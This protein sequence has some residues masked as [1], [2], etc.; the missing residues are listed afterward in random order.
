MKS[1]TDDGFVRVGKVAE[2]EAHGQFSKW[3]EDHEILVFKWKGGIKAL[4]NICPHLGGP[5]GFHKLHDGCFTCVW[6][7]FQFSA[8]DGRLVYPTEPKLLNFRLRE[9]TLKIEDGVIW[10]RLVEV[11]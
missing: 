8:E 7:N 1:K 11:Q 5:V 10:A 9:Y 4:S 2:L 3:I 6:H